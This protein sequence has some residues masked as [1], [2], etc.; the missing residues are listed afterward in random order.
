MSGRPTDYTEE[1]TSKAE[2]YLTEFELLGDQ[3]PSI[4]GFADYIEVSKKTIYNWCQ[5]DEKGNRRASDEFLHALSRIETKQGRV[6]QN[7][8]LSG[9][10]SPVIT[11]LLLSA[12]HGMKEKSDITSNDKEVNA[13]LVKFIDGKDNTDTGGV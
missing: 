8:G 12:N 1:L 13:V 4:E 11:K 6:L 2:K 9:D 7:K 3:I 10:F 5:E